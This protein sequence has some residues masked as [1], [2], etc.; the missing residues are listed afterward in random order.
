MNLDKKLTR[1]SI[2]IPEIEEWVCIVGSCLE[3]GQ[4]RLIWRTYNNQSKLGTI[5]LDKVQELV[6]NYAVPF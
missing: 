6:K 4:F 3:N 2:Y 1:A 5:D